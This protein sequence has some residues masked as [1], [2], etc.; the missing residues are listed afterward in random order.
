M[1]QQKLAAGLAGT[2]I[3]LGGQAAWATD[4]FRLEGIGAVSRAMGG[5]AVAHDVGPGGMLTNPATLSLMPGEQQA[6]VGFDLVTTDIE[7]R[8]EAT[9][10]RKSVV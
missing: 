4:V 5:T 3:M 7:V 8:D 9:G 1:I 6:M 10:D 2:A